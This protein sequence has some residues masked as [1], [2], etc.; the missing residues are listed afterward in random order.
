[1]PPTPGNAPAYEALMQANEALSGLISRTPGS[2]AATWVREVRHAASTV[3][4]ALHQHQAHAEG[5]D[6]ILHDVTEKRPALVPQSAQMAQ[7]HEH[8]LHYARELQREAE[9]QLASEDFDLELVRL[10][11]SLLRDIVQLHLRE[12][13]ALTY[14]AYYR[15]EGGEGG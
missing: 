7:E 8:M 9:L 3:F 10:K 1:M 12:A 2:S 14:E 6:G 13:G 11:A 15:V 4:D 5:D